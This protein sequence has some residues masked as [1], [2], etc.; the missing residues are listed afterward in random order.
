MYV[1]AGREEVGLQLTV[2]TSTE[3]WTT[4]LTRENLAS[5]A[6]KIGIETEEF[7]RETERALTGQPLGSECFSYSV[8]REAEGLRV[9][10]K[11][12]LPKDN[13]KVCWSSRSLGTQYIP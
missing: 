1:L 10:W 9:I 7:I 4:Q 13:V 2:F 3:A 11:R 5:M 8:C 12:H 6:T